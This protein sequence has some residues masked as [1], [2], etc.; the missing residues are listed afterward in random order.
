MTF[1][2]AHAEAD[3]AVADDLRQFLKLHGQISE[4]ETGVHGF[5]PLHMGDVVFLLWSHASAFDVHRLQIERRALEAWADNQLVLVKLDNA[6]APVGLRDL[7]WIDATYAP[8][9]SLN[10]WREA[11]TKA[12]DLARISIGGAPRTAIVKRAPPPPPPKKGGALMAALVGFLATLAVGGLV[13]LGVARG[14]IKL[15]HAMLDAVG[16]GVMV[17]AGLAVVLGLV[18][19]I[20]AGVRRAREPARAPARKVAAAAPPPSAAMAEAAAPGASDDP[21]LFVSYAHADR[22]QVDAVVK[23]AEGQVGNVWMDRQD[24]HAG[25]T[26]AGQIV[27]GIRS[28]KRVMICCSPRAFESDHVKRE[29]YLADRYRKPLLPVFIAEAKPPDDFEFFLASVQWLE[30]YKLSE[31]ERE[32][33]LRDALA[34]A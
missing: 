12:K 7:K 4:S 2:I 17:A 30:L 32:T 31:A 26:W 28:A 6:I 22:V 20:M 5:R 3:Q 13:A 33:A 34:G 10:G 16:W 23:I 15:D 9:R 29:M 21:A 1:Y 11:E 18:C 24:L 19:M 25:D 14:A 8:I 27:R